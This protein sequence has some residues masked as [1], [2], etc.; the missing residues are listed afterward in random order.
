MKL[1]AM[2]AYIVELKKDLLNIE[3]LNN[4]KAK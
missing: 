1:K 3:E 4:G 2:C